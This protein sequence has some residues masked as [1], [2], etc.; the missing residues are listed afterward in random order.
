MKITREHLRHLI[1][2]EISSIDEGWG[3]DTKAAVTDTAAKAAD[4][5]EEKVKTAAQDYLAEPALDALEDSF[6]DYIRENSLSIS[7]SVVSKVPLISMS[8]TATDWLVEAFD[9]LLNKKSD[10][11]GKCVRELMDP[12]WVEDTK[13]KMR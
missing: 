7:K 13:S 9:D 4:W 11:L 5:A 8:E 3:D 12:E 6:T 2:E 10:E 1:V